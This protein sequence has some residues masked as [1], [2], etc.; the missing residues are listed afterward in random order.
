[1]GDLWGST[2]SCRGCFSGRGTQVV[3]AVVVVVVVVVLSSSSSSTSSSSFVSSLLLSSH[4]L[5]YRL[6]SHCWLA[7]PVSVEPT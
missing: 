1:M 7:D 5:S 3:V 2:A 4:R 6:F